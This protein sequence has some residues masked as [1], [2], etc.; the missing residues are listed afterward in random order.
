MPKVSQ[1]RTNIRSNPYTR[2]TKRTKFEHE[3]DKEESKGFCIY[4]V[5]ICA[6]LV[7]GLFVVF[8]YSEDRP[9][10]EM[11]YSYKNRIY[12]FASMLMDKLIY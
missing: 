4:F 5:N 8:A 10:G 12:Q 3:Y 9:I 11:S 1:K 6:Y 7:F 2:D